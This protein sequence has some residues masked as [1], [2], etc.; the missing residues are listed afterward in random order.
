MSV[1]PYIILAIISPKLEKFDEVF[2]LLDGLIKG[3]KD[4]EPDCELF[5]AHREVNLQ[6]GPEEI[7]MIERFKDIEAV[8]FHQKNPAFLAFGEAVTKG[9]L[10]TKPLFIKVIQPVKGFARA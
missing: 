10:L 2:G 7:F 9:N 8:V 3:V 1:E 4:K 6:S 5:Q